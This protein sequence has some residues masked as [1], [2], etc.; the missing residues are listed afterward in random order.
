VA[1]RTGLALPRWL[2]IV[3]GVVGFSLLTPLTQVA[4][5]AGMAMVLITL[6]IAVLLLRTPVEKRPP[7]PGS[8]GG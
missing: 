6:I 4:E 5:V 1:L 3:T 8:T 7:T 2:A